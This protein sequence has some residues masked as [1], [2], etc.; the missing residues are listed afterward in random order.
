MTFGLVFH[1]ALE[2]V[3]VATVCSGTPRGSAAGGGAENDAPPTGHHI[4]RSDD[5]LRRLRGHFVASVCPV[6][7]SIVG[8]T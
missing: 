5:D 6:V 3:L 4:L 1:N 2:T 7:A 8:R